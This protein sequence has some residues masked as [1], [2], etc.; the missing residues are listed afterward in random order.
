MGRGAHAD[1]RDDGWLVGHRVLICDRVKW[2]ARA[3]TGLA[4]PDPRGADSVSG[5]ECECHG[6]FVRSIK[7]ECLD[8]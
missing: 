8:R 2:S 4:R 6:R 5:A 3:G 7:E 1:R